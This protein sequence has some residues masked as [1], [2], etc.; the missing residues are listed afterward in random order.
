MVSMAA[1]VPKIPVRSERGSFHLHTYTPPFDRQAGARA[2]R[3]GRTG[4]RK[5]SQKRLLGTVEGKYVSPTGCVTFS[6]IRGGSE[7]ADGEKK[8]KKLK[9]I[10]LLP[11]AA[12]ALISRVRDTIR[13]ARPPVLPSP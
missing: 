6:P 10:A 5:S 12:A 8:I 9:K 11:L 1:K 4:A 2:A 3:H 13:G 7:L